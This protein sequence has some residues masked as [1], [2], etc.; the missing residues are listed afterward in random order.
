[1]TQAQ[2]KESQMSKSTYLP[3]LLAGLF[4][5]AGVQ[6]QSAPAAGSTD[7][8]PKAGEASTQTQGVPNAQTTNSP[9]TEAPILNKDAVRQEAQGM[10]NAA[11]TS[12]VPPKAGEASAFTQGKPNVDPKEQVAARSRGEVVAELMG[13]RAAFEAERKARIASSPTGHAAGAPTAT[14]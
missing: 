12:S 8:P 5:A 13:R 4:A 3:F 1:M 11:A 14:R 9:A 10:G 2:A 6:A 7:L